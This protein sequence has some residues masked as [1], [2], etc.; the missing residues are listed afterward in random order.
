MSEKVLKEIIEEVGLINR[1][2]VI[3]GAVLAF[4]TDENMFMLGPPGTAKSQLARRFS[5]LLDYKYFE[6]AMQKSTTPEDVFGP[7][8]FTKLKQ[9]INYRNTSGK[10]P[11]AEV[12]LLDEIW[13]SNSTVL[14]GFLPILNE[15]IFYNDGVKKVPLKM[16]ITASNEYP[17]DESLWAVYDRFVF[18]YNVDYITEEDD[19]Y[20]MLDIEEEKLITKH[21]RE[22]LLLIKKKI[23]SIKFSDENKQIL[24]MIKMKL[25]EN[26]VVVTDRKWKK[27]QKVI[28]ASAA[29]HDREKVSLKDFFVLENILWDRVEQKSLV[30][31]AVSAICDPNAMKIREILDDIQSLIDDVDKT[32]RLDSV[33]IAKIADHKTGKEEIEKVIEQFGVQDE[34]IDNKMNQL[35]ELWKKVI[36]KVL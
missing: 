8:S 12:A 6:I 7:L 5:E 26:G 24:W 20:K 21:F 22:E 33:D 28:R 30:F 32:A 36:Q 10:L 4:L 13:K 9:D 19:F 31:E 3:E 29:L 17:E 1:D 23:K 11:E 35:D 25:L 34:K 27:C 14:H 18:R 2:D 15:K 16:A